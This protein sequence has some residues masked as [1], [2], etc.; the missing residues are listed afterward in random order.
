MGAISFS[1]LSSA[2]FG[3]KVN[4]KGESH[5]PKDT[6]SI[7]LPTALSTDVFE[8]SKPKEQT[9]QTLDLA[10]KVIAYQQKMIAALKGTT[11]PA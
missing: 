10:C 4:F 3:A 11:N 5:Q 2:N 6:S 1:A 9:Q 8:C 7:S